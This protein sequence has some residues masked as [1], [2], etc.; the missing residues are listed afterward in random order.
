M[1]GEAHLV[2]AWLG[3]LLPMPSSLVLAARL[4]S[5]KLA[6]QLTIGIKHTSSFRRRRQMLNIL[7]R[8]IRRKYDEG[9]RILVADDGAAAE[10]SVLR[11]L[12]A[13][14]LVLPPRSGLSHGRNA[15]VRATRT[16]FFAL[17]DDDVV[18]DRATTLETLIGALLADPS[19]ALAAGCYQDLRFNRTDCFTLQF[20]LVEGGAVVRG[21]G[22]TTSRGDEGCTRVHAA[23]NFFV[24][25]TALLARFPWDSRQ[26]VMEHETF[27]YQ[28]LLNEQPVLACPS[29][30]V[31]HNTTRDNEYRE[32]S[33]RLQEGRFMQYLCKD[34]PEVA[35]FRTP[36]LEWRCD[37]HTYCGPAWHAQFAY[38]G[39]QCHPMQWD[40][41]DDRSAVRRPLVHAPLINPEERFPPT[42]QKA[43]GSAGGSGRGR[44]HVPLLVL[45]FTEERNT[46][47]RSWQR[48][49]W[50]SFAWHRGYLERELVPWRF[51]YMQAKRGRDAKHV[52]PLHNPELMDVIIGD[53][54][55]LS[56]VTEGYKNLVFKTMEAI[57]WAL[58]H[59]DFEV[60]LKT[61]DDSMVHIGRLWNWLVL[62]RLKEPQPP[63]LARLY[64]GRLF[65]RSQVIRRNFTRQDLWHPDWYPRSFRKWAVD[66]EVY[67]PEAYPPYCGGG[68]YLVGH[69][70]ASL[71]VK[72]YDARPHWRVI[73]VEDVFLG[74]LANAQAIS[75]SEID[76]FQEP[77]RGSHQT[78]EAFI[79][80][81]LVHRVVEP[82]KAFRW[83][84]LSSNCHAGPRECAR[85]HNRT[86]G[87]PYADDD[88]GEREFGLETYF[89]RDWVSGPI[90]RA[91]AQALTGTDG[92]FALDGVSTVG[93]KHG[94]QQGRGGRRDKQRRHGPRQAVR[95]KKR[96]R[97][98]L[99]QSR[100]ES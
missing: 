69:E 18:F 79:D 46:A 59:V 19:A 24:A 12:G 11:A 70:T 28:L 90:P 93:G 77:T 61:D 25:R 34:F 99:Q 29:V 27:F 30:S 21:R 17:L 3:M 85:Q 88:G 98:H 51:L 48:A 6:S 43:P 84:M 97:K 39:R 72:E 44:Q 2:F 100:E 76:T 73:K 94:K 10:V 14:L 40:G 26:R 62:E 86:H 1:A 36:Y 45:I 5:G 41:N 80:Q 23:H 33:F 63:S 8:S 89:D 82:L 66:H 81:I 78:R 58:A 52:P 15:L 75:P 35:R 16:P 96:K 67:A 55:T 31:G 64:A 95:G 54:V 7:L 50:L 68:G 71:V 92:T 37:S 38:D 49:T 9:V 57:R 87:L 13:E 20:D 91:H 32:R 65:R 47:R 53:T 56:A 22:V 42:V 60:L 4:A 74:L 83:L